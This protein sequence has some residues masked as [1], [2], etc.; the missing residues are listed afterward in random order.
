M[1]TKALYLLTDKDMNIIKKAKSEDEV[2][3]YIEKKTPASKLNYFERLKILGIRENT[4][5][6]KYFINAL[7]GYKGYEY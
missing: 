5:H 2:V 7:K 6:T 1:F 4:I 3:N